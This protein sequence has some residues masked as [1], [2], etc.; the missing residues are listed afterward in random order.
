MGTLLSLFGIVPNKLG[1][2]EAYARELSLQLAGHGWRSVLCFEAP[3]SEAVARHL[4]LPNVCL[5]VLESPEQVQWETLKRFVVILRKHRPNI[6]HLHYVGFLGF[7]PWLARLLSVKG[8]YF[9]DH[10]S[11]PPGHIP[12]RAGLGRRMLTRIINAP[13]SGV[14]CVSDYGHRC[15]TSLG[16]LPSN[17][18]HVIYNGVD[19]LRGGQDADRAREFRRKY[20]I[21][22]GRSIVTQASWIMPDKGI[23]DLLEAWRL[24][25]SENASAQ[26]VVVGDGA[27]QDDYV[28]LAARMGIEDHVTWTGLVQDPLGAG[29]FAAADIVCQV[30]RWEEVFGFTIAEAMACGKPV[31]ATRV[32]G[33]P[34]LVQDGRTGFLVPRGDVAKIADRILML[35]PAAELRRRL[36]ESGRAAALAKFD[37]KKNVAQLMRLYGV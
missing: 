24:V 34:E 8:V 37:L 26:L 6:V 10:T 2:Q 27:A 20:G 32:G 11:R 31:I 22:E 36:G 30:S 9:T 4:D 1:S 16:V 13:V 28:R 18:F 21:P 17:R 5:E 14:V 29:V 7:Y 3:P 12:R 15:M 35:L 33:I 19:T 23:G 25:L